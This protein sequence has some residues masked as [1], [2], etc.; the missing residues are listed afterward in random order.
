[1]ILQI[2]VNFLQRVEQ[3]TVLVVPAFPATFKLVLGNAFS[4]FAIRFASSYPARSRAFQFSD[5][6]KDPD[7]IRIF[8]EH[9]AVSR[10]YLS[11]LFK[12]KCCQSVLYLIQN[13]EEVFV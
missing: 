11:I 7:E 8:L 5:L 3:F 6:L 12:L 10:S 9:F 1:M 13:G 2:G 4:D